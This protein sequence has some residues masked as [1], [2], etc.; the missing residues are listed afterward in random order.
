MKIQRKSHSLPYKTT[1]YYFGLADTNDPDS[2]PI[3]AQ[4]YPRI[5]EQLVLPY[6]TADPLS[7]RHY[8][9]SPRFI[10]H[11][12]DRAL[13]LATDTCAVYCRHCFRR[14]FTA[15]DA[16]MI[17]DDQLLMIQNCLHER[18]EIKEVL[19]SGGDPL[20]LSVKIL[21][22]ILSALRDVRDDLI[23]RIS[24]RIPVVLPSRI[25]DQLVELLE[26]FSPLWLIIHSNHPRELGNEFSEAVRR[27][28]RAGLSLLNQAVLLKGVNDSADILEELF[29]GL[30]QNG[31]KPYYLFQGDLASGT[32][33]FRVNILR[34]MEI[35]KELRSRISGMAM[36]TFAVDLPD[37][38]GK[39]PVQQ[40][41]IEKIDADFVYFI[42]PD[43]KKGKYPVEAERIG[44]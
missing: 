12:P 11:Y 4:I 20:V 25:N 40:E 22:K 1:D 38:V 39:V 15:S 43:G 37:G 26:E 33:H 10:H 3:S 29:R 34:G 41:Y 21:R 13:L 35:M 31:V 28:R 36:P 27:L 42:S 18:P 8:E 44:R 30:L 16:G 5:N 17:S 9:I 23:I 32:S 14:H 2:D 6:E 7:D 24:T 19:I